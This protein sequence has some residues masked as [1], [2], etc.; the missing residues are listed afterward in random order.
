MRNRGL[1]PIAPADMIRRELRY[2]ENR[3]TLRTRL[4]VEEM[5]FIQ[6]IVGRAHEGHGGFRGQRYVDT[7]EDDVAAALRLDPW[8]VRRDRQQLIDAIGG[9]VRR[10]IED[11]AP[12]YL[13][14]EEGEPLLGIGSFRFMPVDPRD[15]LRGLYLGGLR[16]TP[17]ARTGNRAALSR[18]DRG[19]RKALLRRYGRHA[20]HGPQWRAPGPG[21]LRGGDRSLSRAGADRGDASDAG[22]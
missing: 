10:A 14:D 3:E 17:E 9:Y 8:G 16:D 18:D 19:T 2:L 5:I 12:G 22:Q 11:K 6:S 21:G 7:G 20:R 13:L 1:P 4:D 15:V